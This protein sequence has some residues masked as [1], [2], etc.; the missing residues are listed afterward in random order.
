NLEGQNRVEVAHLLGAILRHNAGGVEQALGDDDGIADGERLK[1]LSQQSTAADGTRKSDVVVGQNV[2]FQRFACLIK[3][4]GRI[5][6]A[7]LEEARN[8]VVLI[9]LD[10][11]ALRTEGA[12]ILRVLADVGRANDFKRGVL[13]LRWRNLQHVAPDMVNRLELQSAGDA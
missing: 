4:A 2:I 6:E 10:P 5:E 11:G 3:L 7:C 13:R 1:R 8:D 12:D 9:L